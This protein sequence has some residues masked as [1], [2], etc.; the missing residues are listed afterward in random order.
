MPIDP[1]K[2]L[3]L[4]D[5]DLELIGLSD[6]LELVNPEQGMIPA[7]AQVETI[8]P[9]SSVAEKR[10]ALL[11]SM[12]APVD[13]A[14]EQAKHQ[15]NMDNFDTLR[16]A[17]SSD[18]YERM[19]FSERVKT[20]QN[21][22]PRMDQWLRRLAGSQDPEEQEIFQWL[23]NADFKTGEIKQFDGELDELKTQRA[24]TTSPASQKSLDERIIQL[25]NERSKLYE[26][27]RK[28]KGKLPG[29]IDA[30]QPQH[31]PMDAME[32]LRDMG[33]R[34]AAGILTLIPSGLRSIAELDKW[35]MDTGFPPQ[36]TILRKW[37]DQAILPEDW[38]Q[39]NNRETKDLALY[40]LGDEFDKTIKE[41][42]PTDARHDD[43]FLYG[44]VPSAFGN[45][46]GFSLGGM[47]SK[48]PVA[49]P[50]VAGGLLGFDEGY[51]DAKAHEADE[52][53]SREAGFW[54]GIV[55]F[56]EAIP[57]GR[58]LA[59]LNKASRGTLLKALLDGGIEALEE[60]VQEFGQSALGKVIAQQLYD[61]DRVFWDDELARAP[62]AGAISG[63]I[64][65]LIMSGGGN[66][67]Y[68]SQ[69]SKRKYSVDQRRMLREAN[70][71]YLEAQGMSADQIEE[72]LTKRGLRTPKKVGEGTVL[73][74][75]TEEQETSDAVEVGESKVSQPEVTGQSSPQPEKA[76]P[77]VSPPDVRAAAIKVVEES[78]RGMVGGKETVGEVPENDQTD[79][80]RA[81][82]AEAAALGFEMVIVKRTDSDE[83]LSFPAAMNPANPRMVFS[84]TGQTETAIRAGL[85]HE[86]IGHSLRRLDEDAWNDLRSS[87]EKDAP[88]ALKHA[89]TRYSASLEQEGGHGEEYTEDVR[90]EE[91]IGWLAQHLATEMSDPAIG[92]NVLISMIATMPPARR[93]NLTGK[94]LH[95][96]ERVLKRLGIKKT[97]TVERATAEQNLQKNYVMSLIHLR[98]ALT[99]IQ[100]I[101]PTT[102][103][104]KPAPKTTATD[105]IV[106]PATGTKAEEFPRTFYRGTTPG[107]TRRIA[108]PFEAASGKTFVARRGD[109]AKAYGSAVEEV[110]ALPSAKILY[111]ESPEFWR[112][113]RKRR[114]PNGAIQ[115]LSG[116]LVPNVNAAIKAAESAGYDAVSFTS[117]S[118]IGTVILNE[119]AFSRG[120]PAAP[121]AK[122]P[123]V[124]DDV[125]PE[126]ED[127]DEFDPL[128]EP[129][130]PGE[131][132][133]QFAERMTEAIAVNT[134]DEISMEDMARGFAGLSEAVGGTFNPF[135]EG[136]P[137]IRL[138]KDFVQSGETQQNSW[139]EPLIYDIDI[140]QDRRSEWF[141]IL[142]AAVDKS[143][144]KIRAVADWNNPDAIAESL[145]DVEGNDKKRLSQA[146][147]E[148][149]TDRGFVIPSRT[150][151]WLD[152]AISPFDYIHDIWKKHEAA[153]PAAPAKKQPKPKPKAKSKTAKPAADVNDATSIRINADP[154][155]T[156]DAVKA[157]FAKGK[158]IYVRTPLRVTPLSK[159]EHIRLSKSGS[160]QTMEG[161]GR[162]VT[163]TQGQV[164]ELANQAGLK[165]P[166]AKKPK[167]VTVRRKARSKEELQQERYKKESVRGSRANMEKR[168]LDAFRALSN[169][170][171]LEADVLE[172][173]MGNPF[174]FGGELP[175]EVLDLV[176]NK[177]K[178]RALLRPNVKAALG[179][180]I[181]SKLG[182]DKYLAL[183]DRSAGGRKQELDSAIAFLLAEGSP[184]D[185]T[186][187]LMAQI[188]LHGV[189]RSRDIVHIGKLP[190]GSS[191]TINGEKFTVK[192]DFT[193]KILEDGI[194]IPYAEDIGEVIIDKGS[195]KKGKPKP[196]PGKKSKAFDVTDVAEEDF[197]GDDV[198]PFSRY[199]EHEENP[200]KSKLVD[201]SRKS[202]YGELRGVVDTDGKV[203]VWDAGVSTHRSFVNNVLGKTYND[204]IARL[205]FRVNRDGQLT[206]GEELVQGGKLYP[207]DAS[208]RLVKNLGGE[209]PSK[210]I[211][212]K[213][214]PA[215]R[216]ARK[217]EIDPAKITDDQ[218]DEIALIM[219]GKGYNIRSGPDARELATNRGTRNLFSFQE[220]W[221]EAYER[222]VEGKKHQKK[223]VGRTNIDRKRIKALPKTE[224]PKEAGYMLPDGS[225]L[226]LSGK[227]EGG[228]P[229]MRAFDHREAGGTAG[230]QELMDSG[231]I[232]LLPETPGFE[233]ATRPTPKQ[234]RG[235][236]EWI[237]WFSSEPVVVELHDGWGDYHDL[238]DY[239]GESARRWSK[240]YLPGTSPRRIVGDVRKFFDGGD[241][242]KS[243]NI[244]FSR[245]FHGSPFD[246]ERFDISRMG[247]GEGAQTYGWGLYFA[248]KKEVGEF[249]RDKLSAK[250]D[251]Y[252][253]G[254]RLDDQYGFVAVAIRNAMAYG[255]HERG[256]QDTIQDFE[257]RLERTEKN[258]A[259]DMEIGDERALRMVRESDAPELR[260]ALKTLKKLD[261]N[262]AQLRRGRLYEVELA[263]TEDEYLHWDI[264]YSHQPK[265]IH[266]RLGRLEIRPSMSD[267]KRL[268]NRYDLF[269]VSPNYAEIQ[270][271][272][273]IK[274]PIKDAESWIGQESTGER[275][276]RAI[277]SSFES[278][279]GP[280]GM[281]TAQLASELLR[282]RGVRGNKFLNGSSRGTPYAAKKLNDLRTAVKKLK[283]TIAK[284]EGQAWTE[285]DYFVDLLAK[286]ESELQVEE[287]KAA[288][289]PDYNYVIFDDADITV[290]SKFAR[291][292]KDQMS[293][294]SIFHGED[295]DRGMAGEQAN[296]FSEPARTEAKI[297]PLANSL[298][299]TDQDIANANVFLPDV[300]EHPE[301]F[302]YGVKAFQSGAQSPAR[303]D[304]MTMKTFAAA[305]RRG[306]A[307]A[308]VGASDLQSRT[309]KDASERE[310]K[311]DNETGSLF[312]RKKGAARDDHPLTIE[313]YNWMVKERPRQYAL[314]TE[315][316]H[317]L[318]DRLRQLKG[319][320][321][322]K[323]TLDA[324]AF[325]REILAIVNGKKISTPR[326]D[327][328][329]GLKESLGTY[330]IEGAWKYALQHGVLSTAEK[331]ASGREWAVNSSLINCRPDK[332]CAEH[333]YASRGRYTNDKTAAKAELMD[334]LAKE[335]PVLLGKMIADQYKASAGAEWNKKALRF[336]DKG[337]FDS[338]GKWLEVLATVNSHNIRVQVFSRRADI[339][340]QVDPR[341]VRL[342]SVN[343]STPQ[344]LWLSNDL[345]IA[346]VFQGVEDIPLLEVMAKLERIQVILPVKLSQGR[347]LDTD[348]IH[349]IPK[350][351]NVFV[352]PIDK[353]TKMLA[354]ARI[355]EMKKLMEKGYTMKEADRML[356]GVWDCTM[357]DNAGMGLGCFFRQTTTNGYDGHYSVTMHTLTEARKALDNEK[358][359]TEETRKSVLDK[360]LAIEAELGQHIKGVESKT[361]RHLRESR[362]S[363]G[364]GES[365]GAEGGGPEAAPVVISPVRMSVKGRA[366]RFA[367]HPDN[368]SLF[369]DRTLPDGR[370]VRV[371]N[372]ISPI[373]FFS[374]TRRAAGDLKQGKGTGSQMLAM[375]MTSGA[376]EDELESTGLGDWLK[377]KA[378]VTRDEIV[379]YMDQ[380]QVTLE[381][382]V[383]GEEVEEA[384]EVEGRKYSSADVVV[385][386]EPNSDTNALVTA[387]LTGDTNQTQWNVTTP[388][389]DFTIERSIRTVAHTMGQN[390][391]D[392]NWHA[393]NNDTDQMVISSASN[394][395]DA[396][397]AIVFWLNR[398][399]E[400][401][402]DTDPPDPMH[403]QYQLPGGD[404]YRELLLKLPIKSVTA[405]RRSPSKDFLA[406]RMSEPE[407]VHDD[408]TG[409]DFFVVRDRVTGETIGEGSSPEAARSDA[410]NELYS[411]PEYEA[412]WQQERKSDPFTSSHWDGEPNVLV[413]VRFNTRMAWE[414]GFSVF[415]TRSNRRSQFFKTIAE[416]EQFQSTL[417]SSLKT[418]V[419]PASSTVKVL[420]IEEVQSDWH[421]KGREHG[422]RDGKQL[423]DGFS[424]KRSDKV[425]NVG[426][427]TY[428]V[429]SPTGQEIGPHEYTEADAIAAY[430]RVT[431][432]VPD[433][434]FKK[435][436]HEL[437]MR[438]MIRYAVENGYDRV[439]WTTGEQQF[440]R[441]GSPEIAWK[442][443]QNGWRIA[444]IEQRGGNAGGVDIEGE[445]RAQ[446]LLKEVG[447]TSISTKEELFDI[448]ATVKPRDSTDAWIDKTTNRV[449]DRMQKEAAGT[450]LPRK[451]A[452]QEFYD[453]KSGKG[454][455][456]TSTNKIIKKFGGRVKELDLSTRDAA[457]GSFDI[458][459]AHGFDITD[460]LATAYLRDGASLFARRSEDQASVI[461]ALAEQTQGIIDDP[462]R[463]ARRSSKPVKDQIVGDWEHPDQDVEQA[464]TGADGLD[465]KT[466]LSRIIESA[467]NIKATFKKFPLLLENEDAVLIDLLRRFET[468][469]EWSTIMAANHLR[470]IIGKMSKNDR[471]FFA[472]W[473][474]MPDIIK[475]IEQ[476]KYEGKRVPYGLAQADASKEEKIAA[477][478][479]YHE[480]LDALAT[481]DMRASLDN[482]NRLVRAL[483]ERMV[484]LKILKPEVLENDAYYHR[485][486]IDRFQEWQQKVGTP[487]KKIEK[488]KKGFQKHRVGGGDFNLR[489]LEAEFEYLQ[490][491]YEQIN[492]VETL[493]RIE[494]LA[495]IRSDLKR[496][497][498]HLNE[499]NVSG[500]IENW[501]RIQQIRQELNA[502]ERRRP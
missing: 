138:F 301:W 357:C 159:P 362:I 71:K 299:L 215:T 171:E 207:T 331:V 347:L 249:Y 197:K 295:F 20:D 272:W 50:A 56:S 39:Y 3:E 430:Q 60:A 318:R 250:E 148:I 319:T 253:D 427:Y 149:A 73:R 198:A 409:Y 28:E 74:P 453:S 445:A 452:M 494:E 79:A 487:G 204:N 474:A 257:D 202:G 87:L 226:D 129:P 230:M 40:W 264:P 406:S 10:N 130:K 29:T 496:Q 211:I 58:M 321:W 300:E 248:G 24:A 189:P 8:T 240:E 103:A 262:K 100:E 361:E 166:A 234:F 121:A 457:E 334:F 485:Q 407:H 94:I 279:T 390:V 69:R 252:L 399:E 139:L 448:I 353:G 125:Q 437:A 414:Y 400:I 162:W 259:R 175:G 276:Y 82:V 110:H 243:S 191:F 255:V 200:T 33:H 423:P 64:M 497:A 460:G 13:P 308:K 293:L 134:P 482:R 446:G 392:T 444:A 89:W 36:E 84:A 6:D 417:P 1:A 274:S 112:L 67:K 316:D 247:T 57:I 277:A 51:Q 86:A 9:P 105:N 350:E 282:G 302:A 135:Q 424:V 251:V 212:A 398:D 178:L 441:W 412:A 500:G 502:S 147:R 59:R 463:F 499:V 379:E 114:P 66:L 173:D 297:T 221:I 62:G 7:G 349:L 205:M 52:Q 416:A 19:E 68:A 14:V 227:S 450:S 322:A 75:E 466:L 188:L 478:T 12:P 434:P 270:V 411:S 375:L 101:A 95:A 344:S 199:T 278:A 439:G 338:E 386:D 303:H 364:G 106:S 326:L 336:F 425:N 475:D 140:P 195:L 431:A 455:L 304:F 429:V 454:G 18:P 420:F 305:A 489:Y 216:F 368:H 239:Y 193:G 127:V 493:N 219:K 206:V 456:V 327:R 275:F 313:E 92:E 481:P 443:S 65:S 11:S 192:E 307:A 329:K 476:D 154:A 323:A 116:G 151:Q 405:K 190:V 413:H 53:T 32:T 447:G 332:N 339:L 330:G 163:L 470:E 111:Q 458:L 38:Q 491:A 233:I 358:N 468:T 245:A 335:N 213:M 415:N 449:W 54:N 498:K 265:T 158:K 167:V 433:A 168:V 144:I 467:K 376:K 388:Q 228:T 209:D 107:D 152:I 471:R 459:K 196:K 263:P 260:E 201:L 369:T 374:P 355:N 49:F 5:P 435:T 408:E 384:E 93:L 76:A 217:G 185:P 396:I 174:W 287:Q 271:G 223:K 372:D 63:F 345:P 333:C 383:L 157:A 451:E 387:V 436:W 222:V 490:N 438:R 182:D 91:E 42:L 309:A 225:M 108:E 401:R 26:A 210:G 72:Q 289:E 360:I 124:D 340:S 317:G 142:E 136:S 155:A 258:D 294:G 351:L 179:E 367:R 156:V 432:Q 46:V 96:I 469:R 122:P 501:N 37:V 373:G 310:A 244:R 352:C 88:A 462:I 337:D 238:Y 486:V 77:Q 395:Q 22:M 44:D 25:T 288:V 208:R 180:E 194:V 381:E 21:L 229:G 170:V 118:D 17:S 421:Q 365:A 359:I 348:E 370:K 488:R 237:E 378:K 292:S 187:K 268:D 160:V 153:A 98:N 281:D 371:R 461:D 403:G 41:M 23:Q 236:A 342:L 325:K 311:W 261:L 397:D 385:A 31:L 377:S 410:V 418:E 220:D 324:M 484:Q 246:F 126:E 391:G 99:R 363:K 186:A 315:L 131:T 382:I 404:D 235:L 177:P 296:L 290:V 172:D 483:A 102:E 231:Y 4:L 115:S 283:Q 419:R 45:M 35:M 442:T 27:N 34:M 256:L 145:I 48:A 341:N 218:Y 70:R 146:I 120:V 426:N 113:I 109:S 83:Q 143:R 328:H 492:T 176:K 78:N 169:E 123:A 30:G 280:S 495:D 80:D 55:G 133:S 267:G 184:G 402:Y 104:G 394:R 16:K 214:P 291:R 306:F 242:P 465:K 314:A 2:D 97:T 254:K 428:R 393:W 241:M 298:G 464:M 366:I 343:R 477:V 15:E 479:A 346:F 141:G 312:S 47:M 128:F 320:A 132:F 90:K 354:S 440:E 117:D 161:R 43:S 150:S 480:Q 273:G 232:R 85:Y 269:L 284:N 119:A 224:N 81:G 266:D 285:R 286:R 473:I 61:E 181:Y 472:R 183:L 203:Y 422:Y 164:N 380:H 356:P 165:P 389:G 137:L